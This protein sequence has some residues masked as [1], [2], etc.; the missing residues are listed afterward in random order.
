MLDGM[1][2]LLSNNSWTEPA[3]VVIPLN[4][5]GASQFAVRHGQIF[6]TYCLA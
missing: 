5:E 6:E 2:L 4:I 3:V 1:G